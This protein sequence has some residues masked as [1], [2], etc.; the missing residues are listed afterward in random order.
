MEN[1]IM[2]KII[3]FLLMMI[4][5]ST[6][7][8]QSQQIS[9]IDYSKI[10]GSFH[11]NENIIALT[12]G[13]WLGLFYPDFQAIETQRFFSESTK[14]VSYQIQWNSTGDMIA[15][16]LAG[17]IPNGEVTQIWKTNPL[18]KLFEVPYTSPFAGVA[19]SPDGTKFAV[20]TRPDFLIQIYDVN[21]HLLVKEINS[22]YGTTH[23]VWSPLNNYIILDSKN[24]FSTYDFNTGQKIETVPANFLSESVLEISPDENLIAFVDYTKGYNTV[25]LL[26]VDTGNERE[27]VGHDK[28][29]TSLAWTKG[30][31]ITGSY[32]NSLIVWDI[33]TFNGRKFLF[34]QLPSAELNFDGTLLLHNGKDINT[35]I[36]DA[37]SGKVLYVFN[38]QFITLTPTPPTIITLD[39]QTGFTTTPLPTATPYYTPTKTN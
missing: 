8:T 37:D 14:V 17:D 16:T 21:S 38:P 32:D 27:L 36:R 20:T 30:G 24:G 15:L 10:S 2:Q 23:V 12:D 7:H 9:Q 35:S 39:I 3:L 11:P 4:V 19:W 31:L 5:F 25:T 26:N 33:N 28:Y 29:I 22:D 18:E 34:H 6:F 1:K 13:N